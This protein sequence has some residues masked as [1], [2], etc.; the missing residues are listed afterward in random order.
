MEKIILLISVLYLALFSEVLFGNEDEVFKLSNEDIQFL[1]EEEAS[2]VAGDAVIAGPRTP[3]S[4]EGKQN[5][6]LPKKDSEKKFS[7]KIRQENYWSGEDAKTPLRTSTHNISLA[8]D[9]KLNELSNFTYYHPMIVAVQAEDSS[10]YIDDPY[11]AL[12]RKKLGIDN[13]SIQLRHYLPVNISQRENGYRGHSRMY[14]HYQIPNDSVFLRLSLQYRKYWA[15]HNSPSGDINE[16]VRLLPYLTL[17]YEINS[18]ISVAQ[19]VGLYDMWLK[20]G[21]KRETEVY[22]YSEIAY[23]LNP[24]WA[25]ELA[26]ESSVSRKESS[27][28]YPAT[29]ASYYYINFVFS[30]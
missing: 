15:D 7:Y 30:P 19:I 14:L 6:A 13:L 22:L 9:Y 23:Q 1:I 8:V 28:V 26:A 18:K 16:H 29:S 11:L 20:D 27:I 12:E 21:T 3:Q 10:Q 17:A 25:I 2:L 5:V 24:N 4:L